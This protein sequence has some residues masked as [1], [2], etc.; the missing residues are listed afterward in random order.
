[1]ARLFLNGMHGLEYDVI[2]DTG[3]VRRAGF[4]DAVDTE[5]K[6]ELQNPDLVATAFGKPQ[7]TVRADGDAGR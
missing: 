2:S 6:L 3:K 4:H 5:E 1:M 7:V